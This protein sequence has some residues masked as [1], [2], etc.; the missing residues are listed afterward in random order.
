MQYAL[1]I[2]GTYDHLLEAAEFSR[3]RGLVALAVPDHYL[4][5][6]DDE[7]ARTRPAP[8]AFMQ[9]G[10][11]ARDTRDIDLV[12]LVSPIT[13]RHPAVLAKMAVTLDRMSGG[14]FT[15]GLG[16]GWMDREHEVFGIP[17]PDMAERFAML[18]EALGY[19]RAA[20]DPTAPGFTGE[21]YRLEAFPLTPP[22]L[23][24]IP[25]L[26][27]GTGRHKTPRLAGRF[28]DEFNVFPGPDMAERID[29][30]RAAAVEAG[31][32]PDA[33]RLSSAGQV[34]AATTRAEFE[35]EMN[36]RAAATGMTRDELEAHY[37][38]R[39]TPRGTYDEVAEQLEAL[40]RLG[41]TRFYFQ[42]VFAPLDTGRLLDGLGIS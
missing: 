14:R 42:T 35:D 6:L 33:I 38:R 34:V 36:E 9:L 19:V 16:T 25:I 18:E 17:Y 1:H 13:F 7:G 37:D 4:M 5:A 32:D 8:D 27:G 23:G 22:P 3:D 24:E 29:R 11:L 12:M 2:A 20:F 26:V 39:G 41:V 30:F 31:R 40:G 21:R 15:L 10:G 28:A